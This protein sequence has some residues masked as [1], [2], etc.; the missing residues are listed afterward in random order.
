MSDGEDDDDGSDEEGDNPFSCMFPLL[1]K[2]G[3]IGT[4]HSQTQLIFFPYHHKDIQ[5]RA[6]SKIGICRLCGLV[7]KLLWF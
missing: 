1:Y 4:G 6:E 3:R 5:Q 2:K 7:G